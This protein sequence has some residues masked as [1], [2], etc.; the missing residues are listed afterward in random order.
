MST[1]QPGTTVLLAGGSGLIGSALVHDLE[2]RGTRVRRLVR[3]EASGE[4]E[5]SWSPQDGVLPDSA[6]DGVGSV[7]VLSGAGVGDKRWNTAR[8]RELLRS[9][10]ST[11]SLIARRM[12]ELGGPQRL[13]TA[14]AVGY[15]GSRGDAELVETDAPGE[16][17]LADLCQAWEAAAQPARDAGIAV[18]T[19]RTGL[20]LTPEGGA[21]GKLLPLLKL[22]LAGPMGGG[23]QWWP[24]ISLTDEIRALVH[25]I[26]SDVTGPV[27]L[28][29]PEPLRNAELTRVLAKALNRPATVP[30]PAFALRIVLG[31][32]SSDLLASQRVLPAA[33]LADGFE[34]RHP[35]LAPVAEEIIAG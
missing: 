25:L 14:S 21:L 34:F 29:A 22:G 5:V 35:R 30:V 10:T 31:E 20:V 4:N 19:A 2:S 13:L 18:A 32:F 6:F 7:V 9:R 26:G 27:N 15:Y 16:G 28:T 24:W 11:T 12:A 17:F 23:K 8:K 33:L 3:R 1:D